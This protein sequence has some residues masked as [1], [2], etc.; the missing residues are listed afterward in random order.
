[1]WPGFDAEFV[2][3]GSPETLLSCEV[4]AVKT[5]VGR[6]IETKRLPSGDVY[7]PQTKQLRPETLLL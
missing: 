3:P 7:S 2:H 4:P 1:M 5:L 6:P